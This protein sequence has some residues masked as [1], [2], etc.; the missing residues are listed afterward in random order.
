MAVTVAPEG[1]DVAAVFAAQQKQ[2]FTRADGS[3]TNQDTIWIYFTDGSFVQYALIDDE[4][5]VFSEGNFA[6]SEGADFLFE[7]NEADYGTI[8]I[9]RTMKF[10]PGLNYS[11]YASE[12]SYGLKTLGFTQLVLDME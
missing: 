9:S 4:H 7:E 10:Q 12:H 8:T 5:V 1:A 6:L 3:V 2:P 11:E